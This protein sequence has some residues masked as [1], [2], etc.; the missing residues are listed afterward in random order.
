MMTVGSQERDSLV[1]EVA[2]LQAASATKE[3][4]AA[5]Q[6]KAHKAE[7]AALK[8]QVMLVPNQLQHTTQCC[9]KPSLW[10]CSEVIWISGQQGQVQHWVY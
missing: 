1:A 3:E 5:T 2:A 7:I 10:Q 9:H 8:E 6:A 4:E